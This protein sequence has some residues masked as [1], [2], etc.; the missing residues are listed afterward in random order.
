MIDSLID[1]NS[2]LQLLLLAIVIA[3]TSTITTLCPTLEFRTVTANTT[4][5]FTVNTKTIY[6]NQKNLSASSLSKWHSVSR[7]SKGLI[8]NIVQTAE[9]IKLIVSG[10][11]FFFLGGG[12]SATLHQTAQSGSYFW[13][14]YIWEYLN[15][16]QEWL[17]VLTWNF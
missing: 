15:W 4:T 12:R 8:C 1:D 17:P 10:N 6:L 5:T 13:S 3:T 16:S 14:E 2:W 7:L 9:V 11:F